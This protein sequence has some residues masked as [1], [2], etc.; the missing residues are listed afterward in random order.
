MSNETELP[1]DREALIY[2]RYF[3]LRMSENY[4]LEI[5]FWVKEAGPDDV[6]G[7]H[8]SMTIVRTEAEAREDAKFLNIQIQG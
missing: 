8:R 4:E 7:P 1:R 3:P 2:L 6:H 5:R